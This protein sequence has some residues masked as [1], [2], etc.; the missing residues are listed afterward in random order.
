MSYPILISYVRSKHKS[1]IWLIRKIFLW[2]WLLCEPFQDPGLFR[3]VISCTT[4]STGFGKMTDSNYPNRQR[5]PCAPCYMPYENMHV[6]LVENRCCKFADVPCRCQ[7]SYWQQSKGRY[8][9]LSSSKGNWEHKYV[10]E[11]AIFKHKHSQRFWFGFGLLAF[12]SLGLPGLFLSRRE[13]F[14]RSEVEQFE[15]FSHEI[16]RKLFDQ[17]LGGIFNEVRLP[18]WRGN[19]RPCCW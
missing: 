10:H 2:K 12:W 4:P 13:R 8:W 3:G 5:I 16:E 6:A 7:T 18:F 1:V 11:I 9:Q 19:D 14:W 17:I 15:R